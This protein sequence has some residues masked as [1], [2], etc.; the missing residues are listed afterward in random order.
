VKRAIALALFAASCRTSAPPAIDPRLTKYVPEDASALVGFRP[1]TLQGIVPG[2]DGVRYVLIAAR[3]SELISLTL[4][5]DGSV[6]GRPATLPRA[7]SPLLVEGEALAAHN[8]A[9]AVVRGGVALPVEG[10]LSNLNTLLR[11][12]TLVKLTAQLDDQVHVELAADCRTPDAASHFEGSL[13]SLLVLSGLASSVRVQRDGGT[14][15]ASLNA[16]REALG[17]LLHEPG[18][19]KP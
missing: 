14:V 9:W 1:S 12:V 4:S 8:P 16:P 6:N 2:F 3:G 19:R 11:D 7:R 18:L 15:S 5:S 17:K 10:N 13:R